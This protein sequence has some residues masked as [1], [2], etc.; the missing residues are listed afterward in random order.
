MAV[1]VGFEN[2]AGAEKG[3]AV[4]LRVSG[5]KAVIYKCN[6]DGNQDTLYANSFRQFY[7]DVNVWGTIDFVFGGGEAVFQN[8][9]FLLRKS[10]PGQEL[11]VA[12]GGKDRI[13]GPSALVFQSCNFTADTGFS[14]PT[15]LHG[16]VQ[17]YLARPWKQ[18]AKT[19]I[20]DS[21]IDGVY[22]PKGYLA[23]IGNDY[24]QTC[25][26]MEANN[27]GPNG[28]VAKRVM[29][30]GSSLRLTPAQ[31][32]EYY[33]GKFYQLANAAEGDSWIVHSGAPYSL[34][35]MAHHI[36]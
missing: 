7:R 17:V 6:V 5:D 28:D 36:Q 4:A 16:E 21:F 26:V 24:H 10:L 20:I 12:A 33:P 15:I 29:W 8:C 9:T 32:S 22:N 11:V 23:F 13:D 35:P 31:V 3:Q 1:N 25:T 14:S 19:V 18:Y 30:P 34:G 2:T 27:K